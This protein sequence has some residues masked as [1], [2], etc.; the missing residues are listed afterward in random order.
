MKF[1]RQSIAIDDK[2]WTKIIHLAGLDNRSTSAYVRL[3]LEKH[4]KLK[5]RSKK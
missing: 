4:I 2:L 1:K 3:V 5:N